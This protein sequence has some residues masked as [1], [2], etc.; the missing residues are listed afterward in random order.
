MSCEPSGV[1]DGERTWSQSGCGEDEVY[2]FGSDS[3]FFFMCI[4]LDASLALIAALRML[5]L[6]LHLSPAS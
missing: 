3:M 4:L 5:C 6:L 1:H 2:S